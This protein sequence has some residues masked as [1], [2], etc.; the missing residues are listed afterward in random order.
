MSYPIFIITD[1][2]PNLTSK[3]FDLF[4]KISGFEI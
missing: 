3:D 2:D 4:A 1:H